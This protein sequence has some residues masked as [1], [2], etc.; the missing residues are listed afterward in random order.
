MCNKRPATVQ[1]TYLLL[2]IITNKLTLYE[3]YKA[4]EINVN[5]LKSVRFYK[6][7]SMEIKFT[8]DIFVN[9]LIRVIKGEF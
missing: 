2:V 4:H 5:G 6:N 8:A 1:H 9:R 3:F 7:G